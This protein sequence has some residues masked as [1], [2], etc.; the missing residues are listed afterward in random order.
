[1]FYYNY[2]DDFGIIDLP[3]SLKS[4]NIFNKIIIPLKILKQK[5]KWFQNIKNCRLQLHLWKRSGILI[6]LFLFLLNC[7]N[8]IFFYF[9]KV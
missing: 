8:I 5:I 6:P 3:N 7:K 4:R 1:M 9:L 2:F